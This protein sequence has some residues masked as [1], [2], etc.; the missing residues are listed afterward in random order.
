MMN[1]AT[2]ADSRGASVSR[3]SSCSVVAGP[4][5]TGEG[6]TGASDIYVTTREKNG[7]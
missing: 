7:K 5:G 1:T 6:G 4:V 2:I 3:S